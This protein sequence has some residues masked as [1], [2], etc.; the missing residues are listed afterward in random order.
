M[1]PLVVAELVSAFVA[2]RQR[3]VLHYQTMTVQPKFVSPVHT[4]FSAQR[5]L[6]A[7]VAVRVDAPRPSRDM[8]QVVV[9]VSHRNIRQTAIEGSEQRI[10]LGRKCQQVRVGDLFRGEQPRRQNVIG[11][12]QTDGVWNELVHANACK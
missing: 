9:T 4:Q 11:G 3:Q 7:V 6:D 2:H 5:G 1:V 8:K 10:V 12:E